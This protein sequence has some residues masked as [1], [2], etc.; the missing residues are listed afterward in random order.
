[1]GREANAE[2]SGRRAKGNNMIKVMQGEIGKW[3]ILG[4]GRV[5]N[6]GEGCR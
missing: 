4:K 3:R 1:M 6:T 5:V 2:D